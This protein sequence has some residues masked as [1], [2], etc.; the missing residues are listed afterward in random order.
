[1]DPA[2]RARS[3]WGVS[4]HAASTS[5]AFAGSSTSNTT[6]PD[7]TIAM[8]LRVPSNH[9]R[10][11]SGDGRSV[12]NRFHLTSGTFVPGWSGMLT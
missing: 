3:L 8:L 10:Y 5:S 1:M 6:S 2:A 9:S 7:V 4:P 11:C 12:W